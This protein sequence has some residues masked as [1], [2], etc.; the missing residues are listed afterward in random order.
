MKTDLNIV[1]VNDPDIG[2]YEMILSNDQL[3]E[4]G[5]YGAAAIDNAGKASAIAPTT[6][7]SGRIR[8]S[9]DSQ[10]S[11]EGGFIGNKID[12]SKFLPTEKNAEVPA[13]IEK[14]KK[15]EDNFELA[16]ITLTTF[17]GAGLGAYTTGGNPAGLVGV[18]ISSVVGPFVDLYAMD[19]PEGAKNLQGLLENLD[20]VQKMIYQ[21]Q[22]DQKTAEAAA[23]AA[24]EARV[25]IEAENAIR[26]EPAPE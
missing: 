14:A 6:T 7:S 24:E 10:T 1:R 18:P 5:K 8:I 17:V 11:Y 23:K 20:S 25:A 26:P 12:W 2:E 4:L 21:Q 9:G 15:W 19:N 22:L 16:L 13:L 3:K